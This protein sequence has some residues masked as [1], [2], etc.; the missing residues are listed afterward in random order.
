MSESAAHSFDVTRRIRMANLRVVNEK[1]PYRRSCCTNRSTH[2]WCRRSRSALSMPGEG[3]PFGSPGVP[4][5]EA[6]PSAGRL[7][8]SG[9]VPANRLSLLSN[10]MPEPP[11]VFPAEE[12]VPGDDDGDA[13]PLGDVCCVG[14]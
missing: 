7:R 13:R 12:K 4:R 1:H 3:L 2:S 9:V 8:P 10:E 14:E 6:V 11:G 5:V